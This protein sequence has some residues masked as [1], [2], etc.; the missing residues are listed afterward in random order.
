MSA[1][2]ISQDG[3]TSN[4]FWDTNKSPLGQTQ[5]VTVIGT[6]YSIYGPSNSPL[7]DRATFDLTFADPCIDTNFV[8]IT[9]TAQTDRMKTDNFSGNDVVFT[10]EPF[11][12]EAPSI[13]LSGN[14]AV[15]CNGFAPENSFL[16]CE[17]INSDGT[18]TWNFSKY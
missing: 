7:T 17:E 1:T 5:A 15:R 18:I 11:M 9:E 14:E 3:K 6:S 2:A 12:I 8:T 16:S 4:F 10:Y 13:C